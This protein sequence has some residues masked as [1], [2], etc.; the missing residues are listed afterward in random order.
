MVRHSE[1]DFS[2]IDD[3][4]TSQAI[5]L[6][7]CGKDG[8]IVGLKINTGATGAIG[9]A[10]IKFEISDSNPASTTKILFAR[11]GITTYTASSVLTD[12]SGN[13]IWYDG[14]AIKVYF[15]NND[16]TNASQVWGKFTKTAGNITTKLIFK[17]ELITESGA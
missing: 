7:A 15:R 5:A 4:T 16:T 1:T 13:S 9:T 17:V 11:E 8:K 3:T 2:G 12:S 14:N 6:P 10:T